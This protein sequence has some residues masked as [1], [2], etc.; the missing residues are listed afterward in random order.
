MTITKAKSIE[1]TYNLILIVYGKG[2]VSKATFAASVPNPFISRA[3]NEQIQT[4]ALY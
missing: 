4:E 1:A 2:G 3:N